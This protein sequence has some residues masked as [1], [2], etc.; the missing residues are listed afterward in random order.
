MA[1][2]D[3][4]QGHSC[5]GSLGGE[6]VPHP[7]I[8]PATDLAF[9]LR[10]FPFLGKDKWKQILKNDVSGFQLSHIHMGAFTSGHN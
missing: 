2:F 5:I 6:I 7:R 10:S 1:T 4:M 8:Y 9:Q 3:N